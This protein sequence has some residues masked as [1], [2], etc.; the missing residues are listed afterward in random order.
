[1]TEHKSEYNN[2]KIPD[3]L[4]SVIDKSIEKAAKNRK[5]QFARPLSLIAA[6]ILVFILTVN[7]VPAFAKLMNNIPVLSGIIELVRFD[8]G[9]KTAAENGYVQK[10]NLSSEDKGIKLT[11]KDII[12]DKTRL[13]VYYR[14]DSDLDVNSINFNKLELNDEK[15]EKLGG[16]LDL[17]Y[18]NSEDFSSK[19]IKEDIIEIN[20]LENKVFPENIVLSVSSFRISTNEK[21]EEQIIDGNWSVPIKLNSNMLNMEPRILKYGKV[22]QIGPMRFNINDI[23]IYPCSVHVKVEMDENNLYRFCSFV[24]PRLVDGKGNEYAIKRSTIEN[25]NTRV[26]YFESNY[27]IDTKSLE[28]KFDGIFYIPK[29]PQV[30]QVDLKNQRILKNSGY[31]IEFLYA[32]EDLYW[33]NRGGKEPEYTIGLLIKDREIIK[34]MKLPGALFGGIDFSKMYDNN[35]NSYQIS[36]SGTSGPNK[37]NDPSF[38]RFIYTKDIKTP[39]DIINIEVNSCVKGTLEKLNLKVD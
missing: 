31:D 27:S 37:E 20:M 33:S 38:E 1:M 32:R 4:S 25:D 36:G 21:E 39:P 24:N 29:E 23:S 26:L 14:L 19:K 5:Y 28:L 35:G 30:I 8:K 13:L 18:S 17:Y 10:I 12:F 6:S 34:N 22:A 16:F 2:I 11:I 7:I 15:G 3:N 9:L